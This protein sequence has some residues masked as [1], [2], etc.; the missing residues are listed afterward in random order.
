MI[1]NNPQLGRSGDLYFVFAPFAKF[2]Q[3]LPLNNGHYRDANAVVSDPRLRVW[4]QRDDVNGRAHL[5]I[6]NTA[7]QWDAVVA[8]Q[9]IK[10]IS[11][12]ITIPNLKAGT[13]R[14]EWWDTYKKV[15]QVFKTERIAS[16]GA[17][18][19]Q[20]PTPLVTDIAMKIERVN[21]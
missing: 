12:T 15:G 21:K 1:E 3:D 8:D 4:G 6:Q 13:Y 7:H 16:K 11:G 14:V 20:L 2:M 9:S 10:P 19:L 5:W 17:L 18:T